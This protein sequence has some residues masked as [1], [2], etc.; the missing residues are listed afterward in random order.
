VTARKLPAAAFAR[1]LGPRQV[2]CIYHDHRWND[3][4]EVLAISDEPMDWMPWSITIRK[5]DGSV[6]T[7]CTAWDER[8]RVIE[9]PGGAR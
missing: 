9:Q 5:S 8:D 1:E 3:T 6:R 4:Y 7:H 2:G